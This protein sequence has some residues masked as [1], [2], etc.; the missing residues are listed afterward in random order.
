MT[1]WA[2]KQTREHCND[3]DEG[4]MEGV[5]AIA[6]NIPPLALS[7]VRRQAVLQLYQVGI[8]SQAPR[9]IP[10]LGVSVTAVLSARA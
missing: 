2:L 6:L 4:G 10:Q 5:A 7:V 9:H 1:P 3:Q 8:C